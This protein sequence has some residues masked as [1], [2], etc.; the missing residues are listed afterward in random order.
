MN[1]LTPSPSDASVQ[2]L[3]KIFGTGWNAIF[4]SG[5][6][7]SASVFPAVLGI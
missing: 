1:P 3:N 5:G 6:G 4:S 2:L 7:A